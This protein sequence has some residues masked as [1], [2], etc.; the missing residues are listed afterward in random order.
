[1]AYRKLRIVMIKK[2]KFVWS[3]GYKDLTI[4]K[5]Y[6]VIKYTKET[7]PGEY[8]TIRYYDDIGKL[9]TSYLRLAN[10]TYFIDVTAEYRDEVIDGILM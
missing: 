2:V 6:D 9:S 7:D 8:D 4:N 10:S 3:D 1:M 5:V